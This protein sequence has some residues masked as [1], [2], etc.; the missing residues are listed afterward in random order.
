[1]KIVKAILIFL[2]LTS[3]SWAASS[4]SIYNLT[5]KWTNQDAKQVVFSS[6]KGRVRI[7]SMVFTRC[8]AACPMLVSDIKQIL[9]KLPASMSEK[10][11]VDLFSFD[12]KRDN[13]EA[14]LSFTKKMKIDKPAWNAY[15]SDKASI[16]DLAAVLGVQYKVLES[17]AYVHSNNIILI[18]KEGEILKTIEGYDASADEFVVLLKKAVAE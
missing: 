7:V 17:G 16:S 11:L 15:T 1:M 13:P 18:N 3:N 5:S 10:V 9:S 4:T 6:L 14:L 2:F 8:S 12:H